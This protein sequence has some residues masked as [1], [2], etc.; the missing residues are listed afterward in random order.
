[1][2]TVKIAH[3]MHLSYEITQ[4]KIQ[5]FVENAAAFC[6]NSFAIP[7]HFLL[8]LLTH[9]NAMTIPHSTTVKKEDL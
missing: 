9:A 2:C 4:K 5:G 1:M 7:L 3:H 8:Y 6:Y